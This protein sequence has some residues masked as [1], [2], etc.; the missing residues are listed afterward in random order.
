MTAEIVYLLVRNRLEK[1]V[2]LQQQ[3]ICYIKKIFEGSY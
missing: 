1:N 2:G 3:K